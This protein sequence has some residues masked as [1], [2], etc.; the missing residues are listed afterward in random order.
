[1]TRKIIQTDNAPAAI[2]PYSQ[3]NMAGG[4]LFTAGQIPLDPATMEIVGTT[5]AEQA[6]KALENARAGAPNM[7]VTEKEYR[8]V[9]GISVIYMEMEGTLQGTSFTYLGYYYS[10]ETGTTQFITYTG[11]SLVKK[12]RSDIEDFLNGFSIS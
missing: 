9:N 1:M 7:K 3:A 4:F 10:N 8:N 5:A 11:T 2:G 6:Q 12:Y